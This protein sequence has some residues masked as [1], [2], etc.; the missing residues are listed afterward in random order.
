MTKAGPTFPRQRP[1]APPRAC[2]GCGHGLGDLPLNEPCPECDWRPSVRCITCGYDLAG[3]PDEGA[4]PE[5]ATPIDQSMRG[6]GLAFSSVAYL[7]TL[8][9]GLRF[10]R[11]GVGLLF[12]VW[13]GGIALGIAVSLLTSGGTLPWLRMLLVGVPSIGCIGLWVL[14]WWLAT[15]PDPRLAEDVRGRAPLFARW[16]AI[17]GGLYFAGMFITQPFLASSIP[18]VGVV[19]GA[20][21]LGQYGFGAVS[22]RRLA[23]RAG[24]RRA[25]GHARQA[26]WATVIVCGGAAMQ[27]L[28]SIT[29]SQVPRTAGATILGTI[30]LLVGLTIFF[31]SIVAIVR[32]ATAAGLIRDDLRRFLFHARRQ[33]EQGA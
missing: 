29:L 4:C 24:N 23:E 31:T 2:G 28:A 33:R 18:F 6:D 25:A 12:A 22:L 11:L 19:L 16:L 13:V 10:T 7:A 20:L 27:I 32:Q 14:G 1:L 9:R 15:T 17:A 8:D 5:C 21:L 30:V 3:L 26:W